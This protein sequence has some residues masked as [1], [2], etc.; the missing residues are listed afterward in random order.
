MEFYF[1]DGWI[2]C[3]LLVQKQSMWWQRVSDLDHGSIV[4]GHI[5]NLTTINILPLQLLRRSLR[6][7][8]HL[9]LLRTTTSTASTPRRGD[10]GRRLR[11]CLLRL[12]SSSC[13]SLPFWCFVAKGGDRQGEQRQGELGGLWRDWIFMDFVYGHVIWI[14]CMLCVDMS[15]HVLY[16]K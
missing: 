5:L 1:L 2:F 16:F 3:L 6:L 7:S 15:L 4:D 10:R 12:R 14:L 9:P 13:S 11:P 8:A